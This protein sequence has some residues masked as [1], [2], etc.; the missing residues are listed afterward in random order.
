MLRMSST[1]DGKRRSQEVRN[2]CV[3]PKELGMETRGEVDTGAFVAVAHI[4]QRVTDV[5]TDF[6]SEMEHS[7]DSQKP[8]DYG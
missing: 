4:C 8:S 1:E 2:G 5:R 7:T 3:F 6:S